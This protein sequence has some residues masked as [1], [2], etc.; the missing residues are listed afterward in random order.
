MSAFIKECDICHD[1]IGLYTPWYTIKVRKRI[2]TK[3][4][5]K[6]N[7]MIFCTN[8]FHAYEKFLIE[9]EVHENHKR[10]YEDVRN[11]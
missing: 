6:H 2:G 9:Q 10:N 1:K 7:P 11:V 8:C 5:V 4:S 3:I